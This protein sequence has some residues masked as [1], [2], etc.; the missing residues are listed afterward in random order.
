M[1]DWVSAAM[2]LQRSWVSKGQGGMAQAIL[3]PALLP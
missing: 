1:S 2:T 3:H